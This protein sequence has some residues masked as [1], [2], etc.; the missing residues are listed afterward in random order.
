MST[1]RL[2]GIGDSMGVAQSP[3]PPVTMSRRDTIVTD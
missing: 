2:V 3:H 1:I